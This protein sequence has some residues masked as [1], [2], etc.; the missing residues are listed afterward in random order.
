MSSEDIIRAWKDPDQRDATGVNHP[1]GQVELADVRG[2]NETS[3]PCYMIPTAIFSCYIW[4][5]GDTIKIGSCNDPFS[6]IGC[7]TAAE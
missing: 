6:Y 7:C 2:G 5:C 4:E 3:I 1:A